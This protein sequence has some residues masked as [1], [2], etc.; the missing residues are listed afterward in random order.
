MSLEVIKQTQS[1]L[2][3]TVFGS[4]AKTPAKQPESAN[5]KSKLRVPLYETKYIGNHMQQIIVTKVR[6]IDG[7]LKAGNIDQIAKLVMEIHRQVEGFEQFS[8]FAI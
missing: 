1:D 2:F 6:V 7:D 3:D 4:A 5:R 8:N